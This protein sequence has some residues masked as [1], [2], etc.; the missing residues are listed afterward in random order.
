MQKTFTLSQVKRLIITTFIIT[1][2]IVWAIASYA[3]PKIEEH[4]LEARMQ[5]NTKA[6]IGDG[7]TMQE[8]LFRK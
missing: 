1:T 6:I 3:I 5:S 8:R 7:L 2:I 4:S